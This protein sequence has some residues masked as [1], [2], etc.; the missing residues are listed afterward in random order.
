LGRRLCAL[1]IVLLLPL[2]VFIGVFVLQEH[3]CVL[4]I[5]LAVFVLWAGSIANLVI[6]INYNPELLLA[7]SSDGI[8]VKCDAETTRIERAEVLRVE[9]RVEDIRIITRTGQTVVVD[10]SYFDSDQERVT[11]HQ[12]MT[13]CLGIG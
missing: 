5:G 1:T 11:V 7:F 2:P 3:A 6:N 10:D 12:M 9:L 4:A 8:E 13:D